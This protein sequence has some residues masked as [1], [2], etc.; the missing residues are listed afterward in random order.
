MDHFIVG[1]SVLPTP[2]EWSPFAPSS[3]Y[4]D[5]QSELQSLLLVEN[6]WAKI[7]TKQCL[8]PLYFDDHSGPIKGQYPGHVITL[9]QR[10]ASIQSSVF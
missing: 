7:L 2:A 9:E 5:N 6:S 10:E 8:I 3:Y 4:T 1:L